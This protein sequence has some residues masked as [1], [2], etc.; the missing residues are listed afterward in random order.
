MKVNYLKRQK[1]TVIFK[2]GETIFKEGDEGDFM[3]GVV[4]GQVKIVHQG[5]ILETIGE[6]GFVGE[7]AIVGDHR[8][9]A[10]VIAVTDC[11]LAVLNHQEFLW[12]VHETPTFAIQVMAAMA[13]RIKHLNSLVG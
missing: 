7:M 4:E 3:Y 5:T 10:D 8:R 9:S 2:A 6:D 11:K 12:L 13:A 1:E